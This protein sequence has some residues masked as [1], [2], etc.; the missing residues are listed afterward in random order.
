MGKCSALLRPPPHVPSAL[1]VGW[2][3]LRKQKTKNE[4]RRKRKRKWTS[5]GTRTGI[6]LRGSSFSLV[7]PLTLPWHRWGCSSV[8]PA[9]TSPSCYSPPHPGC[10][11][12]PPARTL[13]PGRM[14]TRPRP[15]NS[16]AVALK[17]SNSRFCCK[18]IKN[19]VGVCGSLL[20]FRC[21]FLVSIS[22]SRCSRQLKA[23]GSR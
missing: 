6:P 22:P 1:G 3:V 17:Q 12:S 20:L 4:H 2:Y 5:S 7:T 16:L 23:L 9:A 8:A 21:L 11:N 19:K 14:L 13:W 18:Q 10:G 15:K